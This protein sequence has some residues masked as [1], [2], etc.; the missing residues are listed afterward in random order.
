MDPAVLVTRPDWVRSRLKALFVPVSARAVVPRVLL[1]R[2]GRLPYPVDGPV[3]A[4]WYSVEPEW[5]GNECMLGCEP[6]Q[7][8]LP[9]PE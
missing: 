2:S 9:V 1:R 8:L 3:V 6:Y 4:S 7:D 5:D